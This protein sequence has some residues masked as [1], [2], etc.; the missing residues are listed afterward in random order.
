MNEL[1][2]CLRHRFAQ[3]FARPTSGTRSQ[4]VALLATNECH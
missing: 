2:E 1:I 4:E 3:H